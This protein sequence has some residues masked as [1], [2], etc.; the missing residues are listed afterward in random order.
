MIRLLWLIAKC[1]AVVALA[2]W[3]AGLPGDVTVHVAGW[4]AQLTVGYALAGLLVLMMAVLFLHR[5]WSAAVRSP[6]AL[7]IRLAGNR[8]ERGY[9]ALTLG[10][11]A[12]AAGDAN[13]AR[14]RTREADRLLPE[15]PLVPLLAAQTAQLG[16]DEDAAKRFFERMLDNSGTAFLGYRG[17][18]SQA[19][20]SGNRSEGRRLATL[21]D[22]ERPGTPWVLEA[23]FRLRTADGDWQGASEA[24]EAMARAR[25]AAGA[26]L[27]HRRAVVAIERSRLALAEGDIAGARRFART[28]QKAESSFLPAVVQRARVELARGRIRKVEGIF[29][30]NWPWQ[31]DAGLADVLHDALAGVAPADRIG[32]ARR[33]LGGGAEAPAARLLLAEIAGRARLWDE[34]RS[35]LGPLAD[36]TASAGACRALAAVALGGGDTESARVWLAR[37][38]AGDPDPAWSC[39]SCSEVA[40]QWS[41]TCP[42]CGEFDSLVWRV[43]GG[44]AKEQAAAIAAIEREIES[45]TAVTGNTPTAKEK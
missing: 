43:P 25:V 22:R 2:V 35:L 8:R 4:R 11:V 40:P 18:F 33:L 21:A 10:L 15:A 17:L 23:L 13:E 28:A 24:L 29:R 9:R 7:R 34:A 38:A 27:G 44:G 1:I 3:L 37:A 6:R 30:D 26:A 42:N 20:R 5:V 32:R 12:V 31:G 41:G 45:R 39:G 36:G 14:K 16:G 19:M